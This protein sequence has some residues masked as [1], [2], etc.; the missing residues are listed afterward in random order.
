VTGPLVERG[1]LRWDHLTA[2][3]TEAIGELTTKVQARR[4]RVTAGV[5]EEEYVATVGVLRTMA[6]NLGA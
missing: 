4:A 5:S 6:A 3:G 1:W 2:A